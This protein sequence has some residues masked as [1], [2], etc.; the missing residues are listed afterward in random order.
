MFAIEAMAAPALSCQWRFNGVELAGQTNAHLTLTGVTTNQAG[1]YSVL[2][3]NAFG[4]VISS[5]AALIVVAT[6]A[7]FGDDFEAGPA[8]NLWAV[9]SGTVLATNYGGSVSGTNSLWFGGDAARFATLAPVDTR[10]GGWLDFHL[11]FGDDDSSW[12]DSPFLPAEGIVLEYSVDEGINWVNVAV[13]DTEVYAAWTRQ[14]LPI[15]AG[16]R[17]A[18]TRFRW[19]QLQ[20]GGMYSSH[21]AL[22]DIAVMVGFAAPQITTQPVSLVVASGGKASF[23]VMAG[24]TG[25][26]RYQWQ[27]NGVDLAGETNS[28]LTI[29]EVTTNRAGNYQVIVSNAGASP[30]SSNATLTVVELSGDAFQIT[31]LATTGAVVVGH[32]TI[33]G[34]DRHGLALSATHVFYAGETNT[35]RFA[36]TNLSGGIGLG[37]TYEILASDIQ[38]KLLF[39]PGNGTNLIGANGGLVTTLLEIDGL[40]G[41]LTGN[42]LPLSQPVQLTTGFG[43]FAGYGR[44]V[45]YTGTRIYDVA[46]PSG[47]VTELGAM[48]MPKHRT[49]PQGAFWGV[50][51]FWEGMT[52]LVYAKDSQYLVRT[53][54]PDGQTIVVASAANLLATDAIS[55]SPALNRWYFHR[56]WDQTIGFAAATFAQTITPRAP[57]IYFHPQNQT[58]DADDT[59]IFQVSAF[60]ALPFSC[61]WQW[62][63]IDLPSA[64]NA[65]LKLSRVTA[66]Q[67]GNYTVMVSNALGRVTSARVGL[68]VVRHPPVI[69]RQPQSQ[70]VPKGGTAT[71][72]AWADGT[73]PFYYQWQF[74]SADLPDRT[75]ASLTVNGAAP[76]QAGNYRTVISNSLGSVTSLTATLTVMLPHYRPGS[77]DASLDLTGGGEWMGLVG[78]AGEVT[79]LALHAYGKIVIGGNFRGVERRHRQE[80]ACLSFD[81]TLNADFHLRWGPDQPVLALAAQADG[82]TLMGGAFTTVAGLPRRALARLTWNGSL[83]FDFYP[84]IALGQVNSIVLQPDD[85][86]LIGG[87]FR[88][89]NGIAQPGLARLNSDGSLD[90]GFKPKIESTSIRA[91]AR[92]PDGRLLVAGALNNP[93]RSCTRL[94]EDGSLDAGFDLAARQLLGNAQD[95]IAA[96]GVQSDGMIYLAGAFTITNP[97]PHVR[98]VRLNP[99]GSVDAGFN[100]GAGLNKLASAILVQPDNKAIVGGKFG[101]ANQIT[102]PGL[103]RFNPNGSV[104]AEFNPLNAAGAGATVNALMLTPSGQIVAGGR[105]NPVGSTPKQ[106][107]RLQANGAADTQYQVA[108]QQPGSVYTAVVQSNRSIIIGGAFLGIKNLDQAGLA[109]LNADGSPDVDYRPSL[110]NGSQAPVLNKI[111]LQTN[112]QILILGS[113]DTVN[114]AWR[115]GLARVN[116]DGS[117]DDS[118]YISAL[119][120]PIGCLAVQSDGKI[121]MGGWRTG[122][123]CSNPY[124]GR[125]NTDGSQDTSFSVDFGDCSHSQSG[126]INAITMQTDGRILIGGCFESVNG[127][128]RQGA[129]RLYSNGSLDYGFNPFWSA[130]WGE[131]HVLLM[132]PDGKLLVGGRFGADE[133]VRRLDSYGSPDAQF[134]AVIGE[135]SSGAIRIFSLVRQADGKILLAGNFETING[136]PR[137]GVA[138]LYPDGTLDLSFEPGAGTLGSS[139]DCHLCPGLVVE[140]SGA[141][142]VWGSFRDY[143][144]IPVSGIVRLHGGDATPFI[145]EQPVSQTPNSGEAVTLAVTV[146]GTA[147]LTFQW[148][149]NGGIVRGAT[150]AMLALSKLSR[151]HSGI[152]AVT[153]SNAVGVTVSSN[154]LLS[155]LVPQQLTPP[156]RLPDGG[157]CLIS[158]D[159]DGEPL[160]PGDLA[161]FEVQAST[162]LTHWHKLTNEL[163][164]INGSLLLQ[165][166]DS[167]NHPA[168]FY[169]VLEK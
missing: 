29:S 17:S 109:R 91:I 1:N 36:L 58:V 167:T 54:V 128:A 127:A 37:R 75:N 52:Y 99:D 145:T 106:V 143:D 68:S 114:G 93:R 14:L 156:R 3:S 87:T 155:V 35:A 71:L 102:C 48:V 38:S 132:Q 89:V 26:L 137:Q 78:G 7:R 166:H 84:D 117:L 153:I 81:G 39:T 103:V 141:I 20:H 116:E 5:N 100:T 144:G 73:P 79:A 62:N 126:E 63:G 115:P 161:K 108:V 110:G 86:L 46:L 151:R 121:L 94:N 76:E 8:S 160:L 56:R 138:R 60:S 154:A 146:T 162:N 152:Y 96:I 49:T 157:F 53:R 85:K 28:S 101:L 118:F 135:K 123:E 168:R 130:G 41:L 113:F 27:F 61:Q 55:V 67:T 6:G 69:T 131:S 90:G 124:I 24:G 70:T 57:A 98:I 105:F 142:L 92:M 33:T 23:S 30:T 83:D 65:W 104:D 111:A 107:I 13:H 10:L 66:D 158:N 42:S 44:I 80:V 77:V 32:R 97:G 12:W 25:P 82:K 59:A 11:R 18:E 31:S 163:M 15:P 88:Q 133:N 40:T 150:N 64:T 149:C 134:Q 72:T 159:V 51:E 22:D 119:P 165:D 125:L 164:L 45:L 47:V 140:S 21:W 34:A 2:V 122:Y 19:R 147:P 50:A 74:N 169:R 129:A 43:I 139:A 148:A 120:A 4:S 9:F 136:V 16:A 95:V 112:G